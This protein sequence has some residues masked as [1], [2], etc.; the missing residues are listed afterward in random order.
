M[1]NKILTL[2]ILVVLSSCSKNV[3]TPSSLVGKSFPVVKGTSLAG[4]G[5]AIPDDYKGKNLILLVGYLQKAQF[6]IDRWILGILQADL[7][8]E[9]I[10]LPTIA[11][12]MPQVVQSFIDN[13]MRRGIPKEDWASV[14]TIYEDANKIIDAFGNESPQNAHVFLIDKNGIVI[15]STNRGYSAGQVLSLKARL[16]ENSNN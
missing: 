7:K 10:E 4:S 2:V 6:D 16:E 14:V 11:G 1:K 9:I 15:W 8:A 5:V 12:M 3:P 13:G